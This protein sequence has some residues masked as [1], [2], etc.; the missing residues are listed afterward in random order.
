MKKA[1]RNS[2]TED[3]FTTDKVTTL[4]SSQYTDTDTEHTNTFMCTEYTSKYASYLN[5]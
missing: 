3:E 5:H 1:T 2:H 4:M